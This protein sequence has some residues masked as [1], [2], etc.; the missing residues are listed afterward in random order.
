[1]LKTRSGIRYGQDYGLL[2]D[3]FAEAIAR[4]LEPRA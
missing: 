1:M 2:T 3:F 4:R